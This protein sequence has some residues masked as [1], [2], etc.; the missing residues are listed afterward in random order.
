MYHIHAK[1][2][3]VTQTQ[4]FLSNSFMHTKSRDLMLKRRE[5]RG[6]GRRGEER[7]GEGRRGAERGGEGR[8]GGEGREG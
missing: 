7:G 1:L 2:D 5:E 4:T 6:E 3:I 8:V